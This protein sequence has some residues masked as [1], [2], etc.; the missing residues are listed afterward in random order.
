MGGVKTARLKPGTEM[1]TITRKDIA[2]MAGVSEKTVL[3]REMDWGIR[4]FRSAASAR[5]QLFFRESVNRQLM[6]RRIIN[7]PI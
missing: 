7:H 3:R 2:R 5:P 4:Q 1:E 6:S